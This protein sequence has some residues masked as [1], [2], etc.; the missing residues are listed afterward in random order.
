MSR[1]TFVTGTDTDVGKTVACAYL[2]RALDAD[3]WKPVQSGLEGE[4]DSEAV[5]R[6]TGLPPERF[7]ASAYA[8]RAPLSPHESARRDGV[9]ISL[10]AFALP[11]TP[12]FLL[13]EGAGGV[14][15]PLNADA[16]MVDLMRRLGLPVILVAR[17]TLGTI[18]HTLLSLEALRV[19]GLKVA[20]IVMN[21]P[22]N[23]ANRRALEEYGKAEVIAEIPRLEP[24]DAP[25]LAAFARRHP[26]RLKEV[27]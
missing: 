8:L 4:T 6:L 2:L 3:Y 20:G 7:H 17:S 21:G 25:T 27:A 23:E 15:V 19:R 1:G 16:L 14:L 11:K 12:R 22:P 13:V 18:N 24:L 9:R 26:L 5:Q 10:E